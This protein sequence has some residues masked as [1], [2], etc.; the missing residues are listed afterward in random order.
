MTS[1]ASELD[2]GFLWEASD[3]GMSP[4]D[5]ATQVAVPEFD[6]RIIT[7]AFSFK[8]TGE[9]GIAHYVADPERCERIVATGFGFAAVVALEEAARP[10]RRGIKLRFLGEL[11]LAQ[12]IE[13]PYRPRAQPCDVCG[14]PVRARK[15]VGC[16][17]QS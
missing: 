1:L 9:D 15:E 16:G 17:F 7:T 14:A 2:A 4:L 12:A 11:P 3:D 5:V 10:T 13:A 6:G 8:E